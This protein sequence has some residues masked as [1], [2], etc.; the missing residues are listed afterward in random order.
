MNSPMLNKVK[1]PSG[2]RVLD[3]GA[4]K[5][6]NALWAKDRGYSVEVVEKDY[7]LAQLLDGHF[8][9]VYSM[10]MEKFN[11]TGQY[12]LIIAMNSLQFLPHQKAVKEMMKKIDHWLKPGGYLLVGMFGQRHEWK[13]LTLF[14]PQYIRQ[15]FLAKYKILHWVEE[16]VDKPPLAGGKDVHFHMIKALAQKA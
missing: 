16:E 7:K 9:N 2:A 10:P 13:H 5:G 15:S 14:T 1:L 6:D 11:T 3:L 4:G 8:T 12:D